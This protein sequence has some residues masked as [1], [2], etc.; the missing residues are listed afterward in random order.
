MFMQKDR[1]LPRFRLVLWI[2]GKKKAA[3][4]GTPEIRGS[5]SCLVQ[6]A[7]SLIGSATGFIFLPSGLSLKSQM[8]IFNFFTA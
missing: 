4:S 6:A 3:R 2:Q 5:P 8:K 7:R 1:L